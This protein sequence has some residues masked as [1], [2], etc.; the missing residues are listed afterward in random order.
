M[1]IH[2]QNT[3]NGLTRRGLLVGGAT[4]MAMTAIPAWALTAN[5]AQ[6]LVDKVVNEINAIIGSGQSEQRM[7][8]RFEKLF[9][10][11][12]NVPAIAQQVLGPP[13][14][15]A[16]PAQLRKYTAAFQGYMSRK[17]GKRFREFI[18][19][20]VSVQ[21]ARASKSYFEVLTSAKLAGRAPFAVTFRV[22]S[23]GNKDL[24]FDMLIEGISLIKSERVE[25]NAL[26]EQ[27]KGNLDRLTAD[28][29]SLG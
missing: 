25:M 14:R 26:L 19:G 18:G 3:N 6:A 16:S 10:Q 2:L 8:K 5:S 28:L 15:S 7:I 23:F 9:A 29:K 12:A 17:Y 21:G 4:M 20:Y 11:Y 22:A 27:R 13:A 24:F 1:P